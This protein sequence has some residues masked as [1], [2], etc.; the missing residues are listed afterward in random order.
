MGDGG[1]GGD[2]LNHGQNLSTLHGAM[3]RIDINNVSEINN[4]V[5]P[6]DNP[7]VNNNE[8][9]KEEI[10]AHGFRNPWRFSFDDY[11]GTCWIADVGQDEYEEISIL[12]NGG[13]YGWIL[14]KVFIVSTHQQIAIRQV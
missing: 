8:G 11:T 5:I 2:P 3:L 4:Y 14:W 10:Y 6:F 7:Y 9:N 13:N 1:S 12:E